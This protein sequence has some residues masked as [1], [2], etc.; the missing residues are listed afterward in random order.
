MPQIDVSFSAGVEK[1]R[2]LN[3]SFEGIL[4]ESGS[5]S[6]EGIKYYSKRQEYFVTEDTE[7]TEKRFN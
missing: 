1:L 6:N 3:K 4:E 7:G 2:R 5:F